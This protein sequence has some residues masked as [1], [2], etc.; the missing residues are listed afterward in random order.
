VIRRRV[1]DLAPG[2]WRR[3]RGAA[4]RAGR[5]PVGREQPARPGLRGCVRRRVRRRGGVLVGGDRLATSGGR[6]ARVRADQAAGRR[7][8]GWP[9]DTVDGDAWARS[10]ASSSRTTWSPTAG[11]TP[12]F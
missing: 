4:A 6:A 8:R 3:L 5:G 12:S 11:T 9:P 1:R 10:W 7:C 2:R